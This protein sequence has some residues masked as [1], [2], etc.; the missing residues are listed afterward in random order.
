MV[1]IEAGERDASVKLFQIGLIAVSVLLAGCVEREVI[2]PGE[3]TDLRAAVGLAPADD[4]QNRSVPISLGAQTNHS[5]WPNAAGSASHTIRHPA[6]S[7]TPTRVWS[8][9]IGQGDDR[10]H[11]ITADPVSSGG[12]I[13]TLDSRATVTATSAG[14][15]T[16]W[17]RDLTPP[18]ERSGDASGGG[19]ATAG[20]QVFATTGFGEVVALDTASGNVQWRQRLEAAATGAPTVSGGT[21]YVVSRDS[22]GWA[23][24]AADGRVKWSAQGTPSI[25]GVVGG[26]SPA[27]NGQIVLFPLASTDVLAAL[28]QRGLVVWTGS[29]A[30]DRLGRA[31]ANVTDISGDPVIVGNTVYAG[32]PN[33]RTAALAL[34]D[35][36]PRWSIAE[37]ATGPVLVEGGSVFLVTDKAELMRLDAASGEQIWSV[38]LPY[39]VPAR[40]TRRLRDVFPH[41]GPVLAGGR[42]WVASGD[43]VLRGFDPTNGSLVATTQMGAA[44]ATRP[45]VV[46]GTMYLVGQNG[47]LL[48]FR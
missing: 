18:S 46:N 2:L 7:P 42:L 16:V 17:S 39:F 37:G 15:A 38:G 28:P 31:Y 13:Y 14:G 3:R 22:R 30:G 9:T 40:N 20:G 1:T 35:G 41:Y 19:L 47:Q 45:I 8:A 32:T 25:T 29:V 5:D 10:K 23:L 44:A 27:T 6:L 12:L 24:N 21:V 34:D 36:L 33:G 48:A 43:G 4:P 26:S 11:R